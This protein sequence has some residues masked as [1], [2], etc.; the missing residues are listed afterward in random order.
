MSIYLSQIDA[1]DLYEFKDEV[2]ELIQ[3]AIASVPVK[4]IYDS[5]S[6]FY[7]DLLFE[8]GSTFESHCDEI[9]DEAWD[10]GDDNG[11]EVGYDNG[12]EEGHSEGY[13]EA[14]EEYETDD[15]DLSEQIEELESDLRYARRRIE[16]LEEELESEPEVTL[17]VVDIDD[18]REA[19][20]ADLLSELNLGDTYND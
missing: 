1:Y 16:A 3:K 6:N 12:Y 20:R 10:Y 5:E 11:R 9:A 19:I 13:R 8:I 14:R 4:D 2:Q 7:N 17:P 18:L 15:D